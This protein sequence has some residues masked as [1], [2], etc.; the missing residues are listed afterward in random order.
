M[1]PSRSS[2]PSPTAG[3]VRGAGLCLALLLSACASAPPPPDWQVNAHSDLQAFSQAYLRGNSRVATQAFNRARNETASTGRA[4]QVARVELTRCAVQAASLVFDD[5][6]GY[7]ALAADTAPDSRA[8]AQYLSGR[9]DGLD[10]AQLPEQHRAL[11]QQASRGQPAPEAGQSALNTIADP[12]ARLV[13]AGTLL[14]NGRLTPTDIDAAT[15]TAAAQ[16]WRRPLLAWLYVQ[17][18]RAGAAADGAPAELARIQ[19]RIDLVLQG[20]EID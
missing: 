18:Q 11:V 14:R 13:A 5:C 10:A 2:L 7:L 15:E 9:W 20:G 8:Y 4:E 12:L 3:L 1:T 16:G 6:P 17:R 19:R